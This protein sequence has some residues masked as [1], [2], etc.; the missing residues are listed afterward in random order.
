VC[1]RSSGLPFGQE[2]TPSAVSFDLQLDDITLLRRFSKLRRLHLSLRFD[3]KQLAFLA[4][5]LNAQP[6][7]PI[8]SHMESGLRC[9]RRDSEKVIFAGQRVQ[10]VCRDCDRPRFD[11]LVDEFEAMVRHA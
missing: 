10:R 9:N 6:E 8:T 11:R 5:R 2:R 4:N 3:R 1:G 7:T